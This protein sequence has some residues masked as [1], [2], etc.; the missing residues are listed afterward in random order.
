MLNATFWVSDRIDQ[1]QIRFCTCLFFCI[2]SVLLAWTLFWKNGIVHSF[3]RDFNFQG[4]IGSVLKSHW[5]KLSV[6]EKIFGNLPTD[7]DIADAENEAICEAVMEGKINEDDPVDLQKII[8]WQIA[9][10]FTI[11]GVKEHAE[12]SWHWF[13]FGTHAQEGPCNRCKSIELIP[14]IDKMHKIDMSN[15][16]A[17]HRDRRQIC[18]CNQDDPIDM[19]CLLLKHKNMCSVR[20]DC[21]HC[22]LLHTHAALFQENC[23]F[24][25]AKRFNKKHPI[26]ENGIGWFC[27]AL[28]K[29]VNIND[30][31]KCTNHRWRQ[32]QITKLANDPTVNLTESMAASGHESA[33]A[34]CQCI[35]WTPAWNSV[36]LQQFPMMLL[37]CNLEGRASPFKT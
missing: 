6:T 33:E 17:Q 8:C 37:N 25:N 29:K 2:F 11:R 7:R 3:S 15:H 35:P 12:L 36:W 32:C 19:C 30:W 4:G 22:C 26:R 13:K 1:T 27:Q 24:A 14:S 20:Q 10:C 16:T 23:R 28:T 5:A 31:K 34:N 18:V 21:F 9:K